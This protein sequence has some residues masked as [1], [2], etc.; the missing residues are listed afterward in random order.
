MYIFTTSMHAQARKIKRSLVFIC[1]SREST[2]SIKK[3]CA[4]KS[5]NIFIQR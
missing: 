5:S 4:I 2:N 3:V 1:Q